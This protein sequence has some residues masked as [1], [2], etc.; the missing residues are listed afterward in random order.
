MD[1][2]RNDFTGQLLPL[3]KQIS[4]SSFVSF[5]LEMS[6]INARP[7]QVANTA[8][9]RD[10]GKPTLQQQY[11]ETKSAAEAFQVLQVGITLLEEDRERGKQGLLK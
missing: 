7:K 9:A 2:E 8:G 6:G 11:Q 3:L 5:D 10:A 4:R 1:V